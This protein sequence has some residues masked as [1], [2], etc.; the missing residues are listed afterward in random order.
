MEAQIFIKIIQLQL[1][2]FANQ[3]QEIIGLMI[4][5]N[6]IITLRKGLRKFSI[7]LFYL[8]HFIL[9]ESHLI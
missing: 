3:F 9:F 2:Y 7:L 1:R 8:N 5:N 4:E 6:V